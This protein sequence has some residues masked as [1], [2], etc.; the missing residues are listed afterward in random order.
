M[1]DAFDV[2]ATGGALLAMTGAVT[3]MQQ[4]TATAIAYMRRARSLDPEGSKAAK[5]RR[6]RFGYKSPQELEW[7]CRQQ[8][9]HKWIRRLGP[10]FY[11]WALV[12][13]GAY[14]LAIA[15]FKPYPIPDDW[16]LFS[17]SIVGLMIVLAVSAILSEPSPV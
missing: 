9:R 4:E 13:V 8:G 14:L 2:C 1:V 6:V 5:R 11:A 15:S 16:R 3:Q 12:G 10:T 17:G 7:M